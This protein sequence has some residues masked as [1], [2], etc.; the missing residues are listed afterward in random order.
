MFVSEK[1]GMVF[2]WL[3]MPLQSYLVNMRPFAL[4]AAGSWAAVGIEV[5]GLGPVACG[6]IHLGGG[7]QIGLTS[8]P[9][10]LKTRG[11][12]RVSRNPI[13]LGFFLMIA[14]VIYTF[15]PFVPAL[16]IWSIFI[17]HIIIR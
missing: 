8:G 3:A 12:Y 6:Y 4:G 16:G 15:N 11:I 1:T 2:A 13:Y 17:H 7:N 10:D 9:V 14:A 5:L